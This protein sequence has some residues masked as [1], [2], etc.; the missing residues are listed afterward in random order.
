MNR[1]TLSPDASALKPAVAQAVAD[2]HFATEE[3]PAQ[4]AA[5]SSPGRKRDGEAA[6][7]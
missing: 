1:I 5:A 4:I 3:W 7:A 6:A 2:A